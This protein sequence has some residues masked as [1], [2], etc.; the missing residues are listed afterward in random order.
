MCRNSSPLKLGSEVSAPV[1]VNGSVTRESTPRQASELG[2]MGRKLANTE[3]STETRNPAE[4]SKKTVVY[5]KYNLPDKTRSKLVSLDLRRL[6][7]NA[8]QARSRRPAKRPAPST[9]SPHWLAGD[10]IS[11]GG[12]SLRSLLTPASTPIVSPSR[13]RSAKDSHSITNNLSSSLDYQRKR[14]Q[15]SSLELT[16]RP[17]KKPAASKSTAIGPET[18]FHFFLSD[19]TLGA[20]AHSASTC[21]TANAFF[22]AALAAWKLTASKQQQE[23]VLVGLK[24]SWDGGKRPAV[25]PWRD[26]ESFNKMMATVG[27]AKNLEQGGLDV[28]VSCIV[29]S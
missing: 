11:G 12:H 5:S 27:I 22:D 18:T 24:V 9:P 13:K 7:T 8:L 16:P 2:G 6:H 17:Q 26:A 21:D 3:E 14:L 15:S 23:P 10:N 28:E 1:A 19:P 25:L 4:D 20:V 29:Q